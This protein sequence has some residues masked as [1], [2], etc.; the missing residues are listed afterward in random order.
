M[1]IVRLYA[2]GD[3]KSHF[4]EIEA[5]FSGAGI[6]TTVHAVPFHRAA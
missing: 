2:G 1:K 6:A 3:G 5:R 4:E